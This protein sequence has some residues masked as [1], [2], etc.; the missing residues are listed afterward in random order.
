MFASASHWAGPC[1]SEPFLLF[2]RAEKNGHCV[3]AAR[4]SI[5]LSQLMTNDI[6]HWP[7]GRAQKAGR[8]AGEPAT[9]QTLARSLTLTLNRRVFDSES[10][11]VSKIIA[12]NTGHSYLCRVRFRFVPKLKAIEVWRP[13]QASGSVGNCNRCDLCFVLL[14]PAAF[15]GRLGRAADIRGGVTKVH[16]PANSSARHYFRRAGQTY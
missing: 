7:S 16:F 10:L 14:S 5:S 15:D 4:R 8:R 12:Q 9:K 3:P 11:V 1:N 2:P 13:I 6:D